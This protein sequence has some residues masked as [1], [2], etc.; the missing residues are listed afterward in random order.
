MIKEEKMGLNPVLEVIKNRRSIRS[1]KKDPIPEDDL[2]LILE[3]AIWAPS[4]GNLQPWHFVV[5]R[6]P[7]IKKLLSIAALN[8]TFIAQA[9]VVIV[10]CALPWISSSRYGKRGEELYCLQD[11]AAA[12]ENMLLAAASL[13]IGSCWVGAFDEEAVKKIVGLTN[14]VKPVALIPMGYPAKIPTPP[15]RKP[16]REVV[17]WI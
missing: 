3:A 5:V 13:G 6:D 9:P 1:F 10:V 8:Q 16:I 7:E 14:K 17:S 15:H 11:T 12:I 2:K 4:A